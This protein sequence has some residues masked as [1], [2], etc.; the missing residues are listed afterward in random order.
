M[1]YKLAEGK[2][3][4]WKRFWRWER[5]V[6]EA[7]LYRPGRW[8]TYVAAASILFIMLMVW[9]VVGQRLTP[10]AGFLSGA[11]YEVTGFLMGITSI[12]AAAFTWYEGAHIRI[13]FTRERCGPRARAV[14]DAVGALAFMGWTAAMAWGTWWAAEDA[15]FRGKCSM[16]WCIP[17]APFRFIF[18]GVAIHFALVLLRSFIGASLRAARRSGPE[19]ESA[20]WKGGKIIW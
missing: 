4:G 2:T 14:L 3:E 20:E 10:W 18:F 11:P 19:D 12:V 17:E 9:Y 16:V 6:A 13:T 8:F 1:L 15:L 5:E 7:V